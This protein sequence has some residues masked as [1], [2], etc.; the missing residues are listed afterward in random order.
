MMRTRCVPI[1][2]PNR[3]PAVG[4]F[5]RTLTGNSCQAPKFERDLIRER[6]NAGMT[7]YQRAY[8]AGVIGKERHSRSGKD[9]PPGRPRRIFRR[10]KA[11]LLR[12]GGMSW[13]EISRNLGVPQS[14]IR[15]A[16]KSE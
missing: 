11:A 13:R 4:Q 7:E 6:V 10:D 15:R 3:V 12:A 1:R 5:K 2:I 9:L 14:T 8:R 16:L